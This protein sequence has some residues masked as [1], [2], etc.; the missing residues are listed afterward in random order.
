M[1]GRRPVDLARGNADGGLLAEVNARPGGPSYSVW[2]VPPRAGGPL[3]ERHLLRHRIV[4]KANP[5]PMPLLKRNTARKP[6][7]AEPPAEGAV[8][9]Q[10][11][12]HLT[13]RKHHLLLPPHQRRPNHR[14]QGRGRGAGQR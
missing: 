4:S 14:L 8:L 10:Q 2:Q 1:A 12:L 9:Q 7:G 6:L 3:P 5:I 11:Q 13:N